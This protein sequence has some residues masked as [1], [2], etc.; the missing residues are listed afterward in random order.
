LPAGLNWAIWTSRIL[1]AGRE[2]GINKD[3][4]ITAVHV[5]KS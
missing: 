4:L 2:T 5:F 3:Q 1:P